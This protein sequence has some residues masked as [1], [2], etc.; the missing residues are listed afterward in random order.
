MVP[1]YVDLYFP[2]VGISVVEILER[3]GHTIDYPR[4]FTCCGQPPYNSGCHSDARQVAGKCLSLYEDADV[5]VVPSG[6]CAAMVKVFYADLFDRPEDKLRA[7]RLAAKVWEFSEFL[8][9]KLGVTDMG[10]KHQGQATFHD[11]CHG[12]RELGVK[13]QPRQLLEN[14]QGLELIEMDECETCCGFGGAFSVK[15]PQISTSMA[16]VKSESIGRT[17]AAVVISN[18]PSCLMHLNGYMQKHGQ[19]TRCLHLAE[20]LAGT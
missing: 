2:R 8:V 17:G 14:V 1:C 20:V 7:E 9:D 16:Q 6:S 3:L 15:F 13:S 4:Q 18:D 11:G 12:L 19:G 5:V 10:A